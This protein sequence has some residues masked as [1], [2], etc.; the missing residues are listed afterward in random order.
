MVRCSVT[1]Y[2]LVIKMG[3]LK[4]A[5]ILG[6][7]AAVILSTAVGIFYAVRSDLYTV[8]IVEVESKTENPPLST[9]AILKMAAVPTGKVSLFRLDL[10][11]IERRLLASEWIHHVNIQVRPRDTL[12]IF[13]AYRQPR[14]LI[15][16]KRGALA[17]VDDSGKIYGSA[18][19]VVAQDLPL[20]GGF[21]EQNPE[22]IETAL[23]FLLAWEASAVSA[24][25]TISSIYWDDE[26]GYRALISYAVKHSKSNK[27]SD[28]AIFGRTM[29]DFG[30]DVSSGLDL[31]LSNL[32]NVFRYLGEQ[33]VVV[34]QI[35]ADAGKKIVV[36]TS[37]GS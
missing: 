19:Q 15:Q 1:S 31:R 23:R 36:K 32:A 3:K 12:T 29:V 11:A 8:Q 37:R 17:L 34:R 28:S 13:V 24:F 18:N 16:S 26:R 4:N 35:W 10:K 33:G 7:S 14:A 22:R 25:S 27:D 20:F 21:S 30:A 6:F 5:L 2:D 9:E